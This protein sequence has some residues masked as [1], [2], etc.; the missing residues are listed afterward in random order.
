MKSLIYSFIFI[1]MSYI[2][3]DLIFILT[4]SYNTA[5]WIAIVLP[6][7]I[8]GIILERFEKDPAKLLIP[9]AIVSSVS[10]LALSVILGMPFDIFMLFIELVV[11]LLLIAIFIYLGRKIVK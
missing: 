6:A 10:R 8:I 11:Y 7:L 3:S 1:A 4:D 5:K 9:T 2:T